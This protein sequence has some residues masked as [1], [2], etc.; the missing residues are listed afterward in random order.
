MSSCETTFTNV[1][2]CDNK[3]CRKI[4]IKNLSDA[5][6]ARL[7]T[8]CDQR[9]SYE[10][11]KILKPDGTIDESM[12]SK[13]MVAIALAAGPLLVLKLLG[14]ASPYITNA[15][16]NGMIANSQLWAYFFKF[17]GR[18]IADWPESG[19]KAMDEFKGF[20]GMNP[21]VY[22]KTI[23]EDLKF[24]PDV[25]K[26][27]TI[28]TATLGDLTI[29]LVHNIFRLAVGLAKTVLFKLPG[30]VIGA[31]IKAGVKLTNAA[32]EARNFMADPLG[33][34]KDF[35][36]TDPGAWSAITEPGMEE[37]GEVVAG[38]MQAFT[39]GAG[40]W[41]SSTL[42]FLKIDSILIGFQI[43]GAVLDAW[44]PCK[45]K[46]ELDS[47][48][49]KSIQSKMNS[50]FHNSLYG[51][52]TTTTL[53]GAQIMED[54]WPIPYFADTYA[55]SFLDTYG[56][57]VDANPV[58]CR[59]DSDCP[60]SP[61][62]SKT[63]GSSVFCEPSGYC[64]VPWKDSIQRKHMKY[65][66]LYLNS[67]TQTPEGFPIYHTPSHCAK[68][69]GSTMSNLFA[70]IARGIGVSMGGGNTYV[71]NWI[72]K[73]WPLIFFVITVLLFVLIVLIK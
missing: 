73:W 41:I 63:P 51:Q 70:N 27:L 49:L 2:Y 50:V 17:E 32:I 56:T 37:A 64:T 61:G 52:F 47:S 54:I 67:L 53:D 28:V 42:S 66:Q 3:H 9:S 62:D 30:Y 69:D 57:A 4:Y 24:L 23:V 43:L 8:Y 33:I 71:E 14:K 72:S 6:A 55:Q 35:G 26:A 36:E 25:L 10:H 46:T 7:Q 58:T 11:E 65:Q 20:I 29:T 18:P 39:K 45:L 40:E 48:A 21:A 31:A 5:G 1:E 13:V 22:G 16:K 38:G 59:T 44:D 34:Y 12:V 68:N 19:I 60:P 15:T